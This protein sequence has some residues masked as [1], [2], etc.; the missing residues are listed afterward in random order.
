MQ[1]NTWSQILRKAAHGLEEQSY[2]SLENL[3]KYL[4]SSKGGH[5][6]K[7]FMRASKRLNFKFNF[8]FLTL[9]NYGKYAINRAAICSQCWSPRGLIFEFPFCTL[10]S[11]CSMWRRRESHFS[12]FNVFRVRCLLL[13]SSKVFSHWEQLHW[14]W[15]GLM[16]HHSD[17]QNAELE[18]INKM[19]GADIPVE[20]GMVTSEDTVELD[21]KNAFR[22]LLEMMN[23]LGDE[24]AFADHI[25]SPRKGII[26][27]ILCSLDHKNRQVNGQHT[28]GQYEKH[29][30]VSLDGKWNAQTRQ[31]Y[32]SRSQLR[33]WR[34]LISHTGLRT[35]PV[36]N[37]SFL[38]HL[39]KQDARQSL[40]QKMGIHT[41]KM[42]FAHG[43]LYVLLSWA[44]DLSSI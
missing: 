23:V 22:H 37:S 29:R 33:T 6:Q 43:Q 40:C 27:I 4:P 39:D 35:S 14:W 1:Y 12:L 16:T 5:S 7:L 2:S 15:L 31:T 32:S 24:W 42:C 19:V 36:S 11:L 41:R 8:V 3:K 26:V 30:F 20:I 25:F 13:V 34:R 17:A 10:G 38:C 9:H 21:H 28:C 44:T 18:A